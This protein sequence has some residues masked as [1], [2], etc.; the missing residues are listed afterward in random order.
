MTLKQALRTRLRHARRNIA[1]KERRNAEQEIV[2]RLCQSSYFRQAQKIALYSAFDGE[3]S[4]H[5]ILETALIQHKACYAPIVAN[6]SLTFVKIDLNTPLRANR[7]GI[8]EPY[9]PL[10]KQ[11]PPMQLDIV[12]VPMVGFDRHCHRLGMGGGFYDKTFAFKRRRLK[13]KMIGLAYDFQR[14][15]RIPTSGS[16]LLLDEI[17]TEKRRYRNL[18]I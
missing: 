5:L 17:I 13:P 9:Y 8:F 18:S 16:D 12:V 15:S 7:F 1:A 14:V 4:T 10:M 3:V 11:I 2:R 6:N